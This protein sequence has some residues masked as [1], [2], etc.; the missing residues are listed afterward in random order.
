MRDHEK[1]GR[2]KRETRDSRAGNPSFYFH[3]SREKWTEFLF[4]VNLM[5]D[6][7]ENVETE[8]LFFLYN[9]VQK[10]VIKILDLWKKDI[11]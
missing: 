3:F 6:H 9:S 11:F 8:F 7:A 5:R 4:S 2:V 1:T 10:I